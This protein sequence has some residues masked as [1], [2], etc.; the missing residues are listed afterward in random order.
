[1]TV[2][3]QFHPATQVAIVVCFTAIIIT[4]VRKIL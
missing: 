3:L 4:F 2:F 1:V